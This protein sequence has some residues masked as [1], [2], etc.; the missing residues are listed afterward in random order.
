MHTIYCRCPTSKCSYLFTL[1]VP[2]E[3]MK[4]PRCKK[5]VNLTDTILQ[6]KNCEEKYQMAFEAMEKEEPR[7]AIALLCPAIETFHK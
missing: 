5:T 3:T 2:K 7:K 1:P 4:C 6:M